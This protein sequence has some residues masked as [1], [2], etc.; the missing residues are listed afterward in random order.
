L[1]ATGIRLGWFHRKSLAFLRRDFLFETSYRFQTLFQFLSLMFTLV[2]LFFLA[3]MVGDQARGAHLARYGGDYF[4]YALVG[5]TFLGFFT[6][7]M[8][9]FTA[10]L[11]QQMSVGVLE[12]MAAAPIGSASLLFYSILWPM[13]SELVKALLYVLAG[14]VLF[15]AQISLPRLPIF[16]SALALSV[17]VFG[18]LGIIAGSL[19]VYFKRGDPVAWFFS[20]LSFLAGGVLIPVTALPVW[21]Q[22]LAGRW[23]VSGVWLLKNG[24]PFSVESGSDGPGFGNVDGQGGDR[25]DAHDRGHE[26]WRFRGSTGAWA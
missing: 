20:S 13:G 12:A 9:G 16:L 25:Q 24:T 1:S 7:G 3:R 2:V 5:M 14:T 23:T 18:S 8:G 10:S 6:A 19:L 26:A 15:G 4:S 17:L 11:R 21:I 22:K